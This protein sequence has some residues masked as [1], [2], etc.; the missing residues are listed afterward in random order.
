MK[1]YKKT[2]SN[3]NEFLRTVANLY[4]S[5]ARVFMEY[6][7]NSLDSAETLYVPGQK[8]PYKIKIQVKIDPAK[9]TV[10]FSDNCVG[11]DR[12]VQDGKGNWKDGLL[13]IVTNIGESNK[14]SVPWLNGQFGFGAHAYMACAEKMKIVTT[15]REMDHCLGI[16]ILRDSDVVSPE[17]RLPKDTIPDRSGTIVELSG[18]DKDWWTEVT[19][20]G[21]KDE[22]ETHFEQLL[23]REQVEVKVIYGDEEERCEAFDYDGL[24]G[25]S[26]DIE[27]K[28]ELTGYVR[29]SKLK[30]PLEIPIHIHLK[31]TESVVPNKRP[32]FFN[33]GRRIEEVQKI[34]S[35]SNKSKYRSVIWGHNHLTGFIEVGGLISPVLSRDDF[36]KTDRRTVLY[37]K[38]VAVE[39]EIHSALKEI[40]RQGEDA[41]YNKLGDILSSALSQLARVDSLRFRT[42][43]TEG[44]NQGLNVVDESATVLKRKKKGGKGKRQTKTDQ[45]EDIPVVE[46]DDD[47]ETTGTRHRRSGINVK[48]E[49]REQKTA[50]GESLRSQYI[51][52]VGIIIYMQHSDFLERTASRTYQGELKLNERLIAYLASEAA[53]HYK[54]KFFEKRKKQPEIQAIMGNQEDLFRNVS[55]STYELEKILQPWV[56]QKISALMTGEPSATTQ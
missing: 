17:R 50:G 15:K 16:S 51:E 35:Y 3:Q 21:I 24:L 49:D 41:G 56:D 33:K 12:G 19:P 7:D 9:Q 28:E 42:Y 46:T 43:Y 38:L 36:Q 29:N 34:K 30:I 5:S 48:L 22:I 13:A 1:G 53:I 4:Q 45:V 8:Y 10:I 27:F 14:K 2:I 37:D 31:V 44:G 40:N 18:F 39:D 11:M 52:E 6:I 55:E 47:S 26:I 23:A 32:I 20:Q 54:L 25:K